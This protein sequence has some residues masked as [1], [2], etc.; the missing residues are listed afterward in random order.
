MIYRIGA[1]DYLE[2]ARVQLDK[3]TPEALFYTAFELRCGIEQRMR[4]YLEAWAHVSEKKKRGW[5][6]PDLGRSIDQTFK[7]GDK[8]ARFTIST[9]DKKKVY[10]VFYYTPVSEDLKAMAGRLG[11]YLHAPLDYRDLND[12]WWADSWL[13]LETVHAELKRACSGTLLGA[14]LLSPGGKQIHMPM[15]ADKKA[16]NVKALIGDKVSMLVEYLEEYPT[17]LMDAQ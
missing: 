13:F 4:D 11:N 12:E 16:L 17:E 6:I 15:E 10:G 14:P 8:I 5:K 3:G 9:R 1:R 2:R 7:I